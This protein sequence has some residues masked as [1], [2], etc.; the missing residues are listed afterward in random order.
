M[1]EPLPMSAGKLGSV[2]LDALR[3]DP[4]NPRIP[5][6]HRSKDTAELAT[7]LEMGFEAFPVAQSIAELGFFNAEPLIVVPSPDEAGTW[8]VVEGN[9]RLTALIGLAYPDVRSGFAT[10]ERWEDV[11]KKR[12]I[13]PKMSI[14]VVM[15]QS[16]DTTHAEIARVHV[17]GKLAWRPFM[18]A[19]YIAARVEEG[20]TIQEV[21]DLIG[22]PKSKAADL[23][24][25]QAVLNQAAE[26]GL[27]TSQVESAFSLL[28]V[29]MGS[30]KIRSHVGAPLGSQTVIGEAP[31]PSEK[32]EELKEII[33]W[34]FGDN[35][36]EPLISDSRQIS[37]LGNVVASDV[38]LGAL[39]EG[40]TL[41]EAKQRIQEKG[42]DPLKA[43]TLKLTTARN[44][45]AAASSDVSEFAMDAEIQKLV[46]DIESLAGSIRSTID[47]V[48]AESVV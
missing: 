36:H 15:H 4:E 25:D 28:T 34:V 23:Y 11:A 31:V 10:P 38:G 9:R 3:L 24:R 14:P 39:R 43:L 26:L 16:R 6:T 22:I 29:A 27:E 7:M 8:I 35:E 19:R 32:S 18:Q 30:T 5:E 21:A 47:D 46:E 2:P 42:L 40:K 48:D 37:Q 20:R 44:A 1:S 45:L 12:A 13:S 33:Q 41:E 17:V